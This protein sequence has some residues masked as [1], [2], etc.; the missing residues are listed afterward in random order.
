MHVIEVR[1]VHCALPEM[2]YQ[3]QRK[4]IRRDSRNGP[5]LR[6]PEPCTIKYERP[7]ERVVFWPERAANPFFHLLESLWMLAGR[8]DVEYP[9]S[10][11]SSMRDFSDGGATFHGAYGYRWRVHFNVDQVLKIA[12][13]LKVNPDDRRQVLTMWDPMVDLGADSKDLPCNTHAYLSRDQDGRLDL[14][15]CNRSNDAVWG[16]LGAN[17]V[18]F[19]VLQEVMA[20]LISCPIGRYWQVSNNMHLYLDRH[21]ALMN[22]LADRAFPST[23]TDPYADGSVMVTPIL[24]RGDA[25]QFLREVPMFLEEGLP[26]GMT[27]PFL[28]RVAYPM[29]RAVQAMRS[30]PPPTRYDIALSELMGMQKD[31]DWRV[32]SEAWIRQKK[33]EWEMRHNG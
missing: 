27:S 21:E 8:R 32:V 14:M 13:A 5:V 3:L 6:L 24:P 1:N 16:A 28:R 9:A 10:I 12:E 19:S 18:H 4:G 7:Q 26:L 17:A 33:V 31:S 15:V 11:V 25:A 20:G 29:S 22:T 30:V 23:I 2:M